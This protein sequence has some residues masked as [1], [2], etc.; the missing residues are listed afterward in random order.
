[1]RSLAKRL[2]RLESAFGLLR[3]REKE[4][5]FAQL[6]QLSPEERRERIVQLSVQIAERRGIVPAPGERIEHAVLR[7]LGLKRSPFRPTA[8][9]TIEPCQQN[10]AQ[11]PK[12]WENEF[13]AV[14]ASPGVGRGLTE[15]GAC[16]A[17]DRNL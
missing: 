14:G 16:V 11:I 1:M 8:C 2:D 17:K 7:T 13:L 12:H 15:I 5:I 9:T 6:A 10:T 3:A 4:L